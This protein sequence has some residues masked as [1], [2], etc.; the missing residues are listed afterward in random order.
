MTTL[1]QESKMLFTTDSVQRYHYSL[2]Q[3]HGDF[4][5]HFIQEVF[6]SLRCKSV[7]TS[8]I[9]NVIRYSF[10]H[11]GTFLSL[12][13]KKKKDIFTYRRTRNIIL[14]YSIWHLEN[15]PFFSVFFFFEK[16][17]RYSGI[18]IVY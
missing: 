12:K 13:K 1:S 7:T 18:F 3:C 15:I 2:S 17:H 11:M 5:C 14:G 8:V 16:V 9:W 6:S 4:P 10:P